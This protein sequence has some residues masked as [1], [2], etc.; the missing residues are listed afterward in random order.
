MQHL[1]PK[2]RLAVRR[3]AQVLCISWA[4]YVTVWFYACYF[5]DVWAGE[6]SDLVEILHLLQALVR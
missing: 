3:V 1:T 5:K 2:I 6:R 4:G